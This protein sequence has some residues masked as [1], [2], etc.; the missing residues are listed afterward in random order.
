MKH[1]SFHFQKDFMV[2]VKDFFKVLEEEW[3]VW[4]N[5]ICILFIVIKLNISY[6]RKSKFLFFILILTLPSQFVWNWLRLHFHLLLGAL[7]VHLPPL[8][9]HTEVHNFDQGMLFSFHLHIQC[10]TKAETLS[11]VAAILDANQDHILNKIAF[12]VFLS[13]GDNHSPFILL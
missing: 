12:W 6:Q 2:F 5:L 7:G 13:K 11:K 1:N 10:Q 4:I 8:I 3:E 9:S